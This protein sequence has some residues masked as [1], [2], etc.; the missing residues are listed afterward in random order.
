VIAADRIPQNALSEQY[1]GYEGRVVAANLIEGN[2]RRIEYPAVPSV[3]FTLPPLAF[4]GLRESEARAQGLRFTTNF[5]RTADWYSSRRLGERC[6]AHKVL[7]EEESGRILGAHLLGPNSEEL[8][9][10][11][12][13]A[14]RCGLR[15]GDLKG[16]IF[17][18]PTRASDVAYMV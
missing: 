15:A 16:L 2:T 13:V 17:A 12:A 3:V 11:F 4:V 9:N 14:M 5:A 8:I 18:Y 10:V 7:V 6:S 1:C